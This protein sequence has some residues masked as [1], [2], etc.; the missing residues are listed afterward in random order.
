M[1]FSSLKRSFGF[2]LPAL[3]LSALFSANITAQPKSLYVGINGSDLNSGLS[4]DRPL[5]TINLAIEKAS[6]GDTIFIL[7]GLYRQAVYSK[8]KKGLPENSIIISGYSNKEE[9]YPV[10]DAGTLIPSMNTKDS[11]IR[12]ES[13]EWIGFAKIKFQNGWPFPVKISNS[14]Y[15]SFYKC[16]FFGAKRVISAE[17]LS[18][19]H[20]LVENCF[21][22]QGGEPLWKI[23]QDTKGIDAW[24]SMHHGDMQY[25]NGS[26]IDF[27]GTGGSIVIRGNKITHAFNAIRFRGQKGCDSN[28]EIYDNDVSYV[29]D[30]DFEPEYYTFN[31]HIY[32]NRSHNV[33]RTLSIDNVEGGNIYYYGNTVTSDTAAWTKFICKS[34]WKIYGSERLLS[35]PV[36]AFN[37]SF[38][39]VEKAFTPFQGKLQLLRHF[40][41]AY[42]FLQ[43]DGWALNKWDETNEFDY[44]VLNS[45]WTKAILDNKQELHGKI[46]DVK[47]RDPEN[48]DLRLSAS[49]SAI[50]AGKPISIKEFDWVQSFEGEAPDAGAFEGDKPAEGPPYRF[51]APPEGNLTYMER[52]RI[53]RHKIK[54]NFLILW[55]SEA[56]DPLTVNENSVSVFSGQNKLAISNVYM[57]LNNYEMI[58][59]TPSVVPTEDVSFCFNS[60]PKGLNG[61]TLTYWSS[62]I[63]IKK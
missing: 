11:W 42:Y 4:L 32:H 57:R 44:D 6:A 41:N 30:N 61:E 49:S 16:L 51:L 43:S 5:H 62:S 34:Y 55:F 52:P 46:A 53:V 3:L 35:Y 39:G 45:P 14:S 38:Y 19:H 23:R 20:I 33:H 22:D 60:L 50:D 24:T 7:P 37:N 58:I 25:F 40:N 12:I 31:L 27:S 1:R 56:L 10:I 9:D 63:H 36:Y 13:S 29:R 47:F 8:G 48:G 28:V 18:T 26:L 21:W 54:D 17:G 2:L 59:E 15:I